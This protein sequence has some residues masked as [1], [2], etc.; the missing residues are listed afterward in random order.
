MYT[1][2]IDY[3]VFIYIWL[4]YLIQLLYLIYLICI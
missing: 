4:G 2:K 3:A 1:V